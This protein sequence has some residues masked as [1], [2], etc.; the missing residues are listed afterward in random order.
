MKAEVLFSDLS[1]CI[2]PP[3]DPSEKGSHIGKSF[4]N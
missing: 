3:I 4:K 2:F 1:V